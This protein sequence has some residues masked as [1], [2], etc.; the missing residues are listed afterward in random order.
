MA[1]FSNLLAPWRGLR[2]LPPS[3]WLV[4][5]VSL[6]NRM[7][8]MALP[9][10]AL[11][12]TQELGMPPSR[13]GQVLAA[14]GVGG[15][16]AAPLGGWLSDRIGAVRVMIL[17]FTGSAFFLVAFPLVTTYAMLLAMTVAWALISEMARPATLVALTEGLAPAQ[18]KPAIALNRLAVNLGMGIGPAV[19]GLLATMSFAVLF[20][21]DATTA[22]LA[23]A[24]L[25]LFARRMGVYD[26]TS[27]PDGAPT[28][29]TLQAVRDPLMAGLL[30]GVLLTFLAFEQHR[31]TLPLFLTDTLGYAPSFYGALF[32][33]NTGLI[34]LF[35][36]PLNLATAHWPHRK[37]L[38]L[39]AVLVAAGFGATGLMSGAAWIV[40]TVVVWTLGEMLLFPGMVAYVADVSPDGQR[41]A[42]MGAFGA[43]IWIALIVAPLGGTYLL[44]HYGGGVLW[45][46]V[47]GVGL[48][49]ALAMSRLRAPSGDEG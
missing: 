46:V 4:S 28:G 34:L 12:I 16:M 5:A 13:A 19:G 20:W 11:Y 41:G 17:A 35:E 23:G 8:M 7:G 30:L 3:V 18:R 31:S 14:F 37:T 32:L 10:L 1:R 39:G 25:V 49:A 47:F 42:Y 26:T 24:V 9:F 38:A 29:S 27:A 48:S 6:V 44:E 36:V 21:V 40:V 15:L 43:S 33:V 22:F 2:G 45:A